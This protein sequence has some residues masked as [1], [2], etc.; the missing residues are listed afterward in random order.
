MTAIKELYIKAL[1][2]I[3][4]MPSWKKD[5]RW[6]A[7]YSVC[8]YAV[9]LAFRMSFAG[10]WDHPELWVNG[11]R[12]LA[13]HDAYFW[14]AKAKG[15]GQLSGYPLAEL[16]HALNQFL[17]VSLGTIG[18]WLPAILSSLVGVVCF[19]WGWLLGGRHAGLFAGLV[20]SLTPGFYYRSRLGYFDTDLLTLLGPMLIAWMLA[21]YV[22]LWMKKG[23]LISSS[24]EGA[25]SDQ[26]LLFAFSLS[27]AFGLV[28]RFFCMWHDDIL[29]IS[30]LYFFL[31]AAVI[32]V[33]ARPGQRQYGLYG[34]I[35]FL[36]SAI[37]GASFRRLG[38]FS[39]IPRVPYGL[40]LFYIV[41]A[42]VT[43]VLL[44]TMQKRKIK[45]LNSIWFC[46]TLFFV[47]VAVTGVVQ[48]PLQSVAV[49]LS[50]YFQGGI[51]K[52]VLDS[53]SS[54]PAFP[55][56]VQSII[57]A[58]LVPL[59]EILERGALFP[60]IGWLSLAAT[61]VCVIL[62]PAS[63][64]LFP[65]VILQLLGMKFGVRFSM[66][67]GAALMVFLGI[68]IYSVAHVCLRRIPHKLVV[69]VC[70]QVALGISGLGYCYVKYSKIPLTP[71]LTKPHA[72]ALIEL[73]QSASKDDTIWTWWDWGYA[74]Q[75][76]AGLGTTVDG[77]LHGGKDV[78]P[79]ALVLTT[80][81][82]LQANDMIRAAAQHK[83][84]YGRGYM[85]SDW[86]SKM[87]AKN[88]MEVVDQMREA[89]KVYPIT[90]PQ[91][92]VV[93]WKD[94]TIS[95]WITYFGNWNLETGSTNQASV[96]NF[97]AGQLGFNIERGA[98]RNREGG[99]GLVSDITMLSSEGVEKKE[100]YLN[101]LSPQLL[102]KTRHLLI[103]TV[104]R[105]SVLMDRTVYR[106]T[107]QR[108][109]TGDP[110]DPEISKYFKLVVDKLPFAR[111]YEVVQ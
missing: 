109:L 98:V 92:L 99:G 24:S 77:G 50:G 10:R 30:V 32:I 6:I 108:L 42:F 78:Y 56:V 13:T 44:V 105:Q 20:G 1:D 104:S 106:S 87:P 58:K 45:L 64:F 37:P 15:V 9:V 22:S 83:P 82:F 3:G 88:A 65:L 18:F 67:G 100:Y 89:K 40:E 72:E 111:I 34:L 60:V 7:I 41:L 80:D 86:L 91:Y 54:S 47:S 5:W 52:S 57:E 39:F 96:S 51:E 36:F 93:T 76:Y 70:V 53:V 26:S 101:R 97:Q 102:P 94:L 12:I 21:Y 25:G 38:D 107:M 59:N 35:I 62:K 49:K 11:E 68:G 16:A 74:S 75:Y 46:L 19:L 81:S 48:S 79:T 28:T 90:P 27:F 73:G 29:M 95:K 85:F 23:W 2:G 43:L 8:I 110:N 33:N 4:E 14:L 103:N 71:V 31:A 63:I 84:A 69:I 61:V 17:G 55:S 66:F